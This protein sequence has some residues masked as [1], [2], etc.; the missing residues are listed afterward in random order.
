M[1][2]LQ[3]GFPVCRHDAVTCC[4]ENL[5]ENGA[6]P[7]S[8]SCCLSSCGQAR[9]SFSELRCNFEF[10]WSSYCLSSLSE[11][12]A[13]KAV[14]MAISTDRHE[15]AVITG[16]LLVSSTCVTTRQDSVAAISGSRCSP[17]SLCCTAAVELDLSE[18]VRC[19][20]SRSVRECG[21]SKRCV[22]FKSKGG[23]EDE[24]IPFSNLSFRHWSLPSSLFSTGF[25]RLIPL[26]KLKQDFGR[27]K[28][29]GTGPKSPVETTVTSGWTVVMSPFSGWTM[30]RFGGFCPCVE[31]G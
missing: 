8:R 29:L 4:H 26:Q 22:S 17:T 14:E 9:Q 2:T 13:L 28:C 18:D 15:A 3:A 5:K 20:S 10:T 31:R 24:G 21:E 30:P 11:Q 6:S 7:T 25:G 16:T 19:R 12:C 23:G 1:L 27:R